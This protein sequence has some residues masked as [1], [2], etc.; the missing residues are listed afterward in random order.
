MK[1]ISF[2]KDAYKMA[3]IAFDKGEVPVGA[4]V[5]K[6]NKIIA[7]AHNKTEYKNCAVYH[8]EIIAIEKACRKLNNKYLTDCDLY[9]TLEPCPMCAGAIINSKIKRV[10]IGA[11]DEK[12]GACMSKTNLFT[13]KLFNHSPEV[14]YGFMEDECREILKDFFKKKR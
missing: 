4:V 13:S 3:K 11:L 10:Y 8:A 14:Y 5:V 1:Y 6:D 9:V 12:G 7:K 2:M